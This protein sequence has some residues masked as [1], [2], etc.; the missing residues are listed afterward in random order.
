M[1]DDQVNERVTETVAVTERRRTENS[2]CKSTQ[3]IHY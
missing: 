2:K 3:I 1:R